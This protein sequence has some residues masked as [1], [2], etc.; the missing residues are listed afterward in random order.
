MNLIRGYEWLKALL[1]GRERS[2]LDK[3]VYHQ[4]SL[5]AFLAWVGLGA[6]GLSSVCYGPEEAFK[7]L[8]QHGYL[9][10]LVGL[11]TALTV[12]I[13]GVSYSQTITAFPSG[14]GGYVVASKLL[15]PTLGVVS[16]CALLVDYV[17]TIAI[18]IASGADALFSF[19]PAPWHQWRFMAIVLCVGWLTL[20]NLRGVRESVRPMVPIFLVF[21]ITHVFAILYAFFAGADHAGE[22]ARQAVTQ[23][24]TLLHSGVGLVG[25]MALLLRAYGMGA[26]TYTG[27]EAVSNALPIL[28]EPKVQTAHATMRYMM[29]SLAFMALGLLTAYWLCDVHPV[30]GKTLNAV[31]LERLTGGWNGDTARIFIFVT[32]AAEATILMI[33]A[34]TGFLG[35]PRVLASMALD[36]WVPSFF[37]TLSDHLVT[38]NGVLLMSAA[39]LV[40]L[41]ATGGSV[42]M[43]V[44]LYSINVFI[45]FVLSQSGMVRHWWQERA[46]EPR[47]RSKLFING[48][49][50]FVTGFIL[51]SMTITKFYEGGWITLLFTGLLVFVA[52]LI[53]R[54]YRATYQHL[55]R[56]ND[57]VAVANDAL[58]SDQTSAPT[59]EA[60]AKTA[61]VLVN[62]FNGLG[63]HTLFTIVRTFGN[64]FRRFV[65]VQV[66]VI[67]V[68][69]FKG[70]AEA[71]RL[72]Q[73][74]HEGLDR[75]VRYAHSQG[76]A[77][78][79]VGAVSQDVAD[80]VER[81][82]PDIMKRYPNAVFFGG[83]LVF[84][85]ENLLARWFYN[86]IIFSIQRR[87][88]LLGITFI[89]LP[90]RIK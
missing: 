63:L 59:C 37:A 22:M 43:L 18:S 9:G 25:V 57:L 67:D 20:L 55:A 29:I 48:L 61:V 64:C 14:G 75:Y 13:I 51:I 89:V 81:L 7:A 32:L 73:T 41:W 76:F 11:A 65:F 80:E 21:V 15:T 31:L 88:H 70:V 30:Q 74:V 36:R 82:A 68:G 19:F 45:T 78:E 44:V 49:G 42:T 17:L 2:P 84:P 50:C 47:W 66:G 85:E 62:G 90:I 6:D 5:V 39:A 26:G 53:R 71:E 69:N 52:H 40:V 83:Q 12:L 27:I 72:R 46:K 54:Y 8:G 79:S 16:G 60:N 87:L 24:N 77:A 38:R 33:A 56:L 4:L 10:V 3:K 34:Q 1:L 23:T 58:A 28:R 86:F 35:G